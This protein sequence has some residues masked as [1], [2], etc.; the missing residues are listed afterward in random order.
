MSDGVA[1]VLVER[2]VLRGVV[3]EDGDLRS[4]VGEGQVCLGDKAEGGVVRGYMLFCHDEA[5]DARG[6]GVLAREDRAWRAFRRLEEGLMAAL[7]KR[8]TRQ[9]SQANRMPP[10]PGRK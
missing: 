7:M 2:A 1:L 8:H 9:H 10:S 6:A 5:E 3:R 4:L